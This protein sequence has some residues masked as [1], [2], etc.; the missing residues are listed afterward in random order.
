[1]E[2]MES[3][4]R[5]GW[6]AMPG[7]QEGE[8]TLTEQLEGLEPALAACAG[9]TVLDLGCA[10]G[11]IAQVCIE[12]GARRVHG[13]DANP[14]MVDRAAALGLARAS[15]EH[16]NLN[17]LPE[18][19]I[20]CARADIVLALAIIHKLHE[21]AASLAVL[22]GCARERL[23]IRL[24]GGS[25]GAFY[26]KHTRQWCDVAAVLKAAG[27]VFEAMLPGPRNEK[28]QHWVRS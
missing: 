6:F 21:P 24:P 26:S 1:M 8:R 25:E 27:F 19:F 16:V 11:L 17:H 20:E 7:V 13:V 15:F 28:V 4:R 10:E 22:A 23:A 12:R 18:G 14:V 3:V 2:G 5:R 9:K